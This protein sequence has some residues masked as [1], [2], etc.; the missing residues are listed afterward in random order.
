LISF[1]IILAI[2][3]ALAYQDIMDR[4][5][6]A[7]LVIVLALASIF[8]FYETKGLWLNLFL[9]LGYLSI[10]FLM[11]WLVMVLIFKRDLSK[12]IGMGDILFLLAITPL[13][14][15]YQFIYWFIISIIFSLMFHLLL[16]KLLKM[17]KETI[18]LVGYLSICLI[19]FEINISW[20]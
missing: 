9:N 7:W 11:S 2:S 14:E 4:A 10:V 12:L 20:F 5:V 17:R 15:I 1:I 6:S 18:P 8:Q 16:N 13:F 3:I 19:L